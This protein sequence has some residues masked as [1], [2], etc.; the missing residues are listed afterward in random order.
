[1]TIK[2]VDTVRNSSLFMLI[3]LS[4]ILAVFTNF[5]LQYS[6]MLRDLTQ[7]I[8]W[9]RSNVINFAI[10]TSLIFF[11]YLII[12][13]II[14]NFNI[15]SMICLSFFGAVAFANMKKLSVLGEPL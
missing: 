4:F 15:S 12:A 13:S 6:Q 2:R 3:G 11:I 5:A 10:G 9:I 8:Q 1:M 7:T 14:G